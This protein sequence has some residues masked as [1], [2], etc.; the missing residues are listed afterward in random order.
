MPQLVEGGGRVLGSFFDEG[1]I[2]KVHAVI[3]PMIIGG[4]AA[5]AVVATDR[6]EKK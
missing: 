4:D 2:D 1:L 6:E 5:G 3:A